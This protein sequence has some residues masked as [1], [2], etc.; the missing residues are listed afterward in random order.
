[1][2]GQSSSHWSQAPSKD[3]KRVPRKVRI[4]A[5]HGRLGIQK[6]TPR[7]YCVDHPVHSTAV[8]QIGYQDLRHRNDSQPHPHEAYVRHPRLSG[9]EAHVPQNSPTSSGS[10]ASSSPR[11]SSDSQ[12]RCSPLHLTRR[13]KFVVEAIGGRTSMAGMAIAQETAFADLFEAAFLEESMSLGSMDKASAASSSINL[14]SLGPKNPTGCEL[15]RQFST[16]PGEEAGSICDPCFASNGLLPDMNRVGC[17]TQTC[18]SCTLWSRLVCRTRLGSGCTSASLSR[19]ALQNRADHH[20]CRSA[21]TAC[22]SS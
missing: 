6:G 7:W 8:Q 19:G 17:L 22:R 14:L 21:C 5:C 13:Y 1:M 18:R 11:S 16:G 12:I 9:C 2:H 20:R 15:T 4:D 3:G 10:P